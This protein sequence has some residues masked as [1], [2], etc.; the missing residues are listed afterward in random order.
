[1]KNT[2]KLLAWV[3]AAAMLV[4]CAVM[5]VGLGGKQGVV[6]APEAFSRGVATNMQKEAE[7]KTGDNA[8]DESFFEGDLVVGLDLEALD[9]EVRELI[10][11]AAGMDLSWLQSVGLHGEFGSEDALA[12]GNIAALLNGKAFMDAAFV[13][14]GENG[15]TYLQI[16]ALNAKFLEIPLDLEQLNAD[17]ADK[18]AILDDQE[19]LEAL[20]ERYVDIVRDSIGE[21][22]ESEG[23][24]TLPDGK[25]VDC[26]VRE[27]KL[28]GEEIIKLADAVLTEAR[29][30]ADMK[31]LV[32]FSLRY[33]TEAGIDADELRENWEAKIDELL[34]E[35][36]DTKSED[37]TVSFELKSYRDEDDELRGIEMLLNDEDETLFSYS[38]KTVC[39]DETTFVEADCFVY[40]ED[41]CQKIRVLVSG[42][43]ETDEDGENCKAG[44]DMSV[45]TW[46]EDEDE[47]KAETLEL[48]RLD[49]TVEKKDETTVFQLD[50][51]PTEALMDQLLEESD[52]PEA[53]E[54]QIRKLSL[55]LS[56]EAV[57]G[58]RFET[59]LSLRADDKDVLTL[60]L[61]GKA[62]DAFAIELP[63]D[64]VDENEWTQSM[65]MNG[66]SDVVSKLM[67]AG[68]PAS[69]LENLGNL[70]TADS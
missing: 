6:S 1:M 26:T 24:L 65:D 62:I 22:E 37:I 51:T 36:R 14:D 32:L 70:M 39:E 33:N 8:E 40:D 11:T 3:L 7:K 46:D 69:L 2:K 48:V 55:R 30:D 57:E 29:D 10:E 31:E 19:A 68:L 66:L 4:G 23:E 47:E 15:S 35:V 43:A 58:E 44:F 63:T 17:A 54:K 34:E 18:P 52:I 61:S 56:G 28:E 41:D 49:L 16:P 21:V 53:V 27:I 45:K 5:A 50:V 59:K 64:A 38:V 42:S 12:G 13:V 9:E 20:L 67:E 25:S 60:S